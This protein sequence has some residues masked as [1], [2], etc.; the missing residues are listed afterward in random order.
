MRRRATRRRSYRRRRRNPALLGIRLPNVMNLAVDGAVAATGGLA[1]KWITRQFIPQATGYF[2]PLAVFGVGL[3]IG[4]ALGFLKM[5]QFAKPVILGASVLAAADLIRMTPLG[6]QLG[7]YY[8]PGGYSPVLGEL[9]A[10]FMSSENL[11]AG[12][13]A[14]FQAEE[15]LW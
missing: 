11:A 7:E 3:G 4:T 13:E 1:A 12:A 9:P 14:Q 10:P 2:G 5:Q 8:A 15:N 6:A